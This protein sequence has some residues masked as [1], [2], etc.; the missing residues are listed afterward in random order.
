MMRKN[1]LHAI[2]MLNLQVDAV[3]VQ[4]LSDNDLVA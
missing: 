4:K 1:I 2:N 3:C